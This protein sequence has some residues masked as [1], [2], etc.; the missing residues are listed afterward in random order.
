MAKVCQKWHGTLEHQIGSSTHG[1]PRPRPRH[2]AGVLAFHY[3]SGAWDS[4][5]PVRPRARSNSLC[6]SASLFAE[7]YARSMSTL[8]AASVAV[9]A[10]AEA[11]RICQLAMLLGY[12]CCRYFTTP[13]TTQLMR[14][15]LH[16]SERRRPVACAVL[17][18]LHR[19]HDCCNP[20]NH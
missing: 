13:R 15:S 14:S 6:S 10:P 7:S 3:V 18:S 2:S 11:P 17:H 20:M 12:L 1:D 19:K 9:S 5:A 8:Q 16:N 4:S